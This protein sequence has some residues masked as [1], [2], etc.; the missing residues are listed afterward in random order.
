MWWR[1]SRGPAGA[2]GGGGAPPPPPH[3]RRRDRQAGQTAAEQPARGISDDGRS[4]RTDRKFGQEPGKTGWDDRT[5]LTD[6]EVWSSVVLDE[7]VA[8]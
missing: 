2:L 7:L 4:R 6:D 5:V 8:A 1:R 3:A